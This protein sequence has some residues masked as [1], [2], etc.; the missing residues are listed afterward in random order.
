MG[1]HKRFITKENI[2]ENISDVDSYLKND[3]LLFDSWSEKFQSEV[4]PEEREIRNG[5]NE[6]MRM[7][8]G[9][10]HQHTGFEDLKSH[11][12]CLISLLTDPKWLDVDFV[13]DKVGFDLTLD[14]MGRFDILVEKSIEALI[15]YFDEK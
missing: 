6:N 12:E 14:E 7:S 8:S 2:L 4:D 11:S 13:K 3:T 1:S 5:I 10:S 15:K 9:T